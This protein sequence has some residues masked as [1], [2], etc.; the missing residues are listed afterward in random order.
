MGQVNMN[1]SLFSC[2]P[3]D[4]QQRMLQDGMNAQTLGQ[5]TNQ[6][7]IVGIDH[8]RITRS[9]ARKQSTGS[10]GPAAL[11]SKVLANV[12]KSSGFLIILTNTFKI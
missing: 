1:H 9:A 12:N 11:T 3:K 2:S 5:D 6:R 4:V 10:P 8:R 7:K